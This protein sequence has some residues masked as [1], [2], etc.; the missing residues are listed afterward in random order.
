MLDFNQKLLNSSPHACVCHRAELD[1]SNM[2]L[3]FTLEWGNDAFF[4]QFKSLG[5]NDGR[6]ACGKHVDGFSWFTFF[7]NLWKGNS[8][9]V[10][11]H[12]FPSVS[13]NL[14][15]TSSYLEDDLIVTW[16]SRS[17]PESFIQATF[18]EI[19]LISLLLEKMQGI[20][21]Q[22]YDSDRKV[23]FWN[24]AS[25][26]MYGYSAHEAFG[27]DIVDLII[28]E[29]IKEEVVHNIDRMLKTGKARSPEFL[30][31][32]SKSGNLL[33]VMSHHTVL[34]YPKGEF[35]LFCIDVDMSAKREAD[36]KIHKLSRVV[37]QSPVSIVITDNEGYVE[38][39]NPVFCEFTGFSKEEVLGTNPRFAKSTFLPKDQYA[40]LWKTVSE[41]NIWRG[42]LV[43]RKK[44]GEVYFELATISPIVNSQN[45][46]THFICIK[47]DITEKKRFEQEL[48]DAR[49]KA[50]ESDLLKAAFLQNMSHEIR[51]PMNAILGFSELARS[52][53]LS[54]EKRD[55]YLSIVIESTQRL[56]GIVEDIMDISRLESGDIVLKNKPV[57]IS[58]VLQRIYHFFKKKIEGDVELE[59]PVIDSFLQE[60]NVLIDS[61][62]LVQ[63]LDKLLSNAV[64]FTKKGKIT[65]GCEK[66]DCT[67]RFFV[68]DTGIGIDPDVFSLIF[69]PFYQLDMGQTRAFGGNGLGLTIASRIVEKMG[70]N[71]QIESL[72][73]SGSTF[74]FDLVFKNT[75]NDDENRLQHVIP[76][77]QKHTIL[78]AEVDDVNFILFREIIS[79]KFNEN[80]IEI[81]RT[82]SGNQTIELCREKKSI[83]LIIVD[84]RMPDIDGIS[85]ARQIKT[86]C[87]GVPVI[88]QY[89]GTEEQHREK[90][91]NAGCDDF[92]A[93]PFRQNLL[94]SKLSKYLGL[95]AS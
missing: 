49:E 43:N 31:L 70:S 33:P 40:E 62:R 11:E 47:Q 20:A 3:Y 71:I 69:Q 89:E 93:K 5:I 52:C 64:K 42:E 60:N 13:K 87:P 81:I 80:N 1:K 26:D 73:G 63:V 67:V 86:I 55:S 28:P 44:S 34:E 48:F 39:V 79:K 74:Y 22:G 51:T 57:N 27:K 83:D 38:Y 41:G 24:K 65:F 18:R 77:K 12:Y 68:E 10:A 90:M 23:K 78:V 95:S 53:D 19:P 6:I 92:I 4:D 29:D 46:I 16:I 9:T 17:E 94:I 56:L 66:Q 59:M 82:S 15:I 84:F 25:E 85:T 72:P 14:R 36:E 35:I 2:P 91:L 21:V 54:V 88:G 75:E 50:K 61:G 7:E 8:E 32:K 76:N 58:V 30:Q 45:E 37:E